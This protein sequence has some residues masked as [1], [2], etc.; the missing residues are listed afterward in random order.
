MNIRKY[1]KSTDPLLISVVALFLFSSGCARLQT[2]REDHRKSEI[3]EHD[4][5]F[6]WWPT[7]A[8]PGPVKDEKGGGYWWWPNKP[9]Q[10]RPWGNRGYIYN[11]K[12]IFDYMAED[13]PTEVAVEQ[14]SEQP[15]VEA[16]KEP[17][18]KPS[19]IIRKIVRNVKIYFDY[20]KTDLRGDALAVL[21]KAVGTLNRHPETDILVTGNADIR[22]SENYNLKLA[23]S[24]AESVKVFLLEKGIPEERIKIVSRGKLDAVAPV[25]DL[26]GM[27]KDRNVQF[28]I[29]EVEEVMLP[30]PIDEQLNAQQIEEG[31]YL[32]EEQ[33][34][35]EG[36]VKVT[37]RDYTIRRGDTLEKIAK[38]YLGASHRAKYLLELNQDKINN[39]KKLEPGT[40]I[41]IPVEVDA[42][43][44][45]SEDEPEVMENTV[46]NPVIEEKS[47]GEM[48][49]QSSSDSQSREYVVKKGDTL[50]EI[51]LR[52]LGTSKRWKEILELNKDRIKDPKKIRVGQKILL[53]Q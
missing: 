32:V 34:N 38:K 4:Q 33:E 50:G 47:S 6:Q 17:E 3:E 21:N 53:P 23:K 41:V 18:L 52:E 8:L 13:E 40:V 43:Q 49:V 27:Q 29:A 15:S 5:R 28:M 14:P 35:L 45:S 10:S 1:T 12:I 24:R 42:D 20:D 30:A 37:T 11:Q 16:P 39:P 26:V 31:K 44:V 46:S 7:D 51:A 9:G 19:L 22:G 25:T 36:Q 48:A 2:V